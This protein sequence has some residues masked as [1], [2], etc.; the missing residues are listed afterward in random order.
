MRTTNFSVLEVN[1]EIQR[2]KNISEKYLHRKKKEEEEFNNSNINDSLLLDIL[3]FL[4]HTS[5]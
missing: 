5:K 4:S 2:E 3:F 1:I